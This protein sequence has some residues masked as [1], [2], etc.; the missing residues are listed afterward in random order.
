MDTELAWPSVLLAPAQ[1][2]SD[3][4]AIDYEESLFQALVSKRNEL[5]R[6][7]GNVPAYTIF[8]NLVLKKLAALKPKTAEEAMMIKGIGPAKA[9]TILP[10]FLDIVARHEP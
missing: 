5:R 2:D 10:V 1:T 8:P 9:E 3:Q 4:E 7:R 6:Q